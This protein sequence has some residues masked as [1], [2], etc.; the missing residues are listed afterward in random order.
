LLSDPKTRYRDLL[1]GYDDA[2]INPERKK[3]NHIR[4]LEAL[5]HKVILEPVG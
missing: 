5:G 4:E 3:R 1:S 2:R